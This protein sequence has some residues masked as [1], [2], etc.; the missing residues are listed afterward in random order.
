M[1]SNATLDRVSD[2]LLAVWLFMRD[3]E[4][5]RRPACATNIESQLFLLLRSILYSF[6]CLDKEELLDVVDAV[7]SNLGAHM[8]RTGACGTAACCFPATSWVSL[9]DD[10]AAGDCVLR[11]ELRTSVK[12]RDADALLARHLQGALAD[13]HR[14]ALCCYIALK[15][16]D[17][18]YARILK[19]SALAVTDLTSASR[20]GQ[21]RRFAVVSR[22]EACATSVTRSRFQDFNQLSFGDPPTTAGAQPHVQLKLVLLPSSASE[23]SVRAKTLSADAGTPNSFRDALKIVTETRFVL[24][25]PASQQP[26]AVLYFAA[27]RSQAVRAADGGRKAATDLF[28]QWNGVRYLPNAQPGAPGSGGPSDVPWLVELAR[29]RGDDAHGSLHL[30]SD[31]GVDGWAQLPTLADALESFK[32]AH[33]DAPYNA[34]VGPIALEKAHE[35]RLPYVLKAPDRITMAEHERNMHSWPFVLHEACLARP[36]LLLVFRHGG[37]VNDDTLRS[38]CAALPAALRSL[39]HGFLTGV[40]AMPS[41]H[42]EATRQQ[43]EHV[44][45]RAAT[46][47]AV[48]LACRATANTDADADADAAAA[49]SGP[50]AAAA[51]LACLMCP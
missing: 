27:E 3:A 22:D 25:E 38:A 23:H 16:D 51:R 39:G 42:T 15:K 17:H 30:R 35:F 28:P 32:T 33:G 11:A 29:R 37:G 2:A 34:Y 31:G 12:A 1:S 41:V 4:R 10:D 26:E 21:P 44:M 40:H 9:D 19:H 8:C 45:Q 13:V 43:L 47:D 20:D 6:C 48:A 24:E 7:F 46:T 49:C 50:V 14:R 18:F 5:R 36:V